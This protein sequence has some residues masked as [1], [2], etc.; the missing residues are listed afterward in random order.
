MMDGRIIRIN[1][2]MTGKGILTLQTAKGGKVFRHF[3]SFC[4]AKRIILRMLFL[5]SMH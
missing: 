5:R 2:D 1:P 3:P 4:P